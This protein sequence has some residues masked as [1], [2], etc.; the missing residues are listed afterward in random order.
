MFQIEVKR[1]TSAI[2]A[3][4]AKEPGLQPHAQ[5]AD[6][7]TTREISLVGATCE[8]ACATGSSASHSSLSW[9]CDWVNFGAET[10]NWRADPRID[11]PV[12]GHNFFSKSFQRVQASS[13]A[14]LLASLA[15]GA[16]PARMKPWPAPSYVT[17]S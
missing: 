9:K 4:A 11:S 13:L 5:R 7:R 3:Q 14:F 8:G 17:G 16:A 12:T 6:H 1:S 10:H 2:A 15:S